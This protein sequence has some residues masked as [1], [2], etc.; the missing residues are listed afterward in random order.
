[1]IDSLQYGDYTASITYSAEDD[2][3]FGKVTGINDLVIFEGTSVDGLKT[4]FR[5]AI[6][7]YLNIYN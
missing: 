3:F 7:D 5:E 1:M 6:D 2:V 4:A